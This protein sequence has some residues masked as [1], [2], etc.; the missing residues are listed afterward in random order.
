MCAGSSLQHVEAKTKA[1]TQRS[2][3][4][5]LQPKTGSV[6][7]A[8]PPEQQAANHTHARQLHST[9]TG[10]G[11]AARAKP[12]ACARIQ[13][14]HIVPKRAEHGKMLPAA[15]A[16]TALSSTG[17]KHGQAHP[18]HRPST[19]PVKASGQTPLRSLSHTPTGTRSVQTAEPAAVPPPR[20]DNQARS[21]HS[22]AP[23]PARLC[24]ATPPPG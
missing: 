24:P 6:R 5:K 14:S 18:T 11:A 23:A 19:Q 1:H 22:P 3:T 7:A 21:S 8:A 17:Q 2:A 15:A 4:Q 12:H 13:T 10:R 9:T 20:H 16:E